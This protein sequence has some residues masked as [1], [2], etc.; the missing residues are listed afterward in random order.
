MVE[1]DQ[2]KYT[3]STYETPLKE[4]RD[5]LNLEAKIR[6][7]DELDKTMEEPSFWEDAEK[8]TRLVKEAKNLKDT[9]RSGRS[10]GSGVSAELLPRNHHGLY[11]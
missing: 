3:L 1:L 4:V 2:F 8:S 7:I 10:S 11:L 9:D 6:R 5:S